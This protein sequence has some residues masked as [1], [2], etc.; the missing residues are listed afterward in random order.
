MLKALIFSTI[1]W[2]LSG[3]LVVSTLITHA[4]NLSQFPAIGYAGL[5]TWVLA[6]FAWG[7][8]AFL[9]LK[10]ITDKLGNTQNRDNRSKPEK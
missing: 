7:I 8:Y 9:A 5:W 4:R 3:I 1:V 6:T 10:R 2:A